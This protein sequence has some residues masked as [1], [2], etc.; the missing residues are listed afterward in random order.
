MSIVLSDPDLNVARETAVETFH[1]DNATVRLFAMA[2]AGWA[3]T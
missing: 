3:A 1:Y 2:T